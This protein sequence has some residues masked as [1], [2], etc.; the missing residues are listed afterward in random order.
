MFPFERGR[1]G[2]DEVTLEYLTPSPN[3]LP[4]LETQQAKPWLR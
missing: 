4:G 1:E 3:R 2:E